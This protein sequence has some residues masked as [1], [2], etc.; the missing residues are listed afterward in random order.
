MAYPGGSSF[1]RI[2]LQIRTSFADNATTKQIH[3]VYGQLIGRVWR[4][5]LGRAAAD[6]ERPRTFCVE[7]YKHAAR[8]KRKKDTRRRLRG[9]PTVLYTN[10]SYRL[11]RYAR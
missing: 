7:Q 4:T 1:R 6:N 2:Y 10:I 9:P 3:A 5:K 11:V 8:Q